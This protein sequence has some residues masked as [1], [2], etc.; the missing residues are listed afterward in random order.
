MQHGAVNEKWA[1]ALSLQPSVMKDEYT[2][3]CII[4]DTN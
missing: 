1:P 3:S 2:D 4:T